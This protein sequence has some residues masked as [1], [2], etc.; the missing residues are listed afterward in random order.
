MA[1]TYED[2]ITRAREI[3]QDTNNAQY[4]YSDQ[5]MIN[6]VNDAILE[7]QRVRPDLLLGV[8]FDPGDAD[9]NNLTIELP[10]ATTFFQSLV[11]M[12][13]GQMMLRDDEF[14]VDARA[15]QLL[16]KGLAQLITV[17]A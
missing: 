4:R 15:V 1:R 3:L 8:S 6:A 12:T 2:V 16:N 7:I 11:Y 9:L 14:A 13:A 5:S 10:V 17:T